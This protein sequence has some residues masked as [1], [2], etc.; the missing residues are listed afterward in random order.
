MERVKNSNACLIISIFQRD[1]A[2]RKQ[3]R[4]T[5]AAEWYDLKRMLQN[6]ET[7]RVTNAKMSRAIQLCRDRVRIHSEVHVKNVKTQ[8]KALL[9]KADD[10]PP[11]IQI[12]VA[13]CFERSPHAE[14]FQLKDMRCWNR[15]ST[16]NTER[17]VCHT[18]VRKAWNVGQ[19]LTHYIKS[20]LWIISAKPHSKMYN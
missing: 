17:M 16:I 18:D 11:Y 10:S 19:Y 8:L 2:Y 1:F 14:S 3:V 5:S 9:Q 6:I 4:K 12:P 13:N 20:L 7:S 15:T